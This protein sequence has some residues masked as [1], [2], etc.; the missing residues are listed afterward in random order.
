M[1]GVVGSTA[2]GV[3]LSSQEVQITTEETTT[4]TTYVTTL[5]TITLA[6]RTGGLADCIA[7]VV[8][9]NATLAATAS[10]VFYDDDAALTGDSN[11]T[12]VAATEYGQTIVVRSIIDLNGSVVT[13]RMKCSSSTARLIYTSNS[14]E[15]KFTVLE[16]S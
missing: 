14:A 3:T 1:V 9:S 8:G 4:S 2:A 5:L 7:T 13:L 11:V 16:I 12:S 10:F 6:T 15:S